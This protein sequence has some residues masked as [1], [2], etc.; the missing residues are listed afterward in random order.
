MRRVLFLGGAYQQIPIIKEARAAGLYAITCDYLPDNPGHRFSDEYHNI[1]TTDA[2]AVLALA[3]KVRA[4]YVIAY[5]S[6]PNAPVAAYVAEELGLP[7]NT[8]A[9][10]RILS[11]KDVFREFLRTHGFNTP[12]AVGMNEA[13][14]DWSLTEGFQYPLIVKPVDSS[15]SKGVSKVFQSAELAGAAQYALSFSRKKRIVVEEFIEGNG[16]QLTGDGFVIDGDL[17]FSCFADQRYNERVNPFVPCGA[18]WPSRRPVEVIAKVHEEAGKIIR[19]AG[20]RNGPVNIEARVS[21]RDD[22]YVMEIGPRSGGNFMPQAIKYS[23]GF[24]MVRASL[25][26][27]MGNDVAV[28]SGERECV[29]YYAVHSEHGGRLARLNL[30]DRLKACVKEFHQYVF[31]GEKA[32]SF[33]GSNAALGIVLLGFQNHQDMEDMMANI[34]S[35]VDIEVVGE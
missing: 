25:D 10:V 35:M 29:A 3:R 5:A 11:E 14:L 19:A 15:G 30:S 24:D 7:G 34:S 13:G 22:V 17:V 16:A 26:V 18:T 1:S 6:D 21:P 9:S 31:P 8:Y 12:R 27:L 33:Q 28:P 4:D 2:E 20:L 32:A 23:T